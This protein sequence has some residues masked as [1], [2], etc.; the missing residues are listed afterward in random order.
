M[1]IR[2]SSL[3][4][5]LTCTAR[6]D[7]R[8]HACLVFF[9]QALFV[10]WIPFLLVVSIARARARLAHT[11]P[12]H[13]AQATAPLTPARAQST[14]SGLRCDLDDVRDLRILAEDHAY[15]MP[16]LCFAALLLL[17]TTYVFAPFGLKTSYMM[18]LV[19]AHA[20]PGHASFVLWCNH[21]AAAPVITVGFVGFLI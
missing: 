4:R 21:F 13:D 20:L 6:L 14:D 3:P 10:L 8:F 1:C 2:D 19:E 11:G 9:I 12:A 18:S 15:F 5:R 16:R 17:G 7:T